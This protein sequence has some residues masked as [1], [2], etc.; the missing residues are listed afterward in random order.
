MTFQINVHV[1]DKEATLFFESEE[2]KDTYVRQESSFCANARADYMG[3]TTRQEAEV[4]RRKLQETRLKFAKLSG[5]APKSSG[6]LMFI[7]EFGRPES[8]DQI[9]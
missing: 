4:L 6:S 8:P 1:G 9:A 3:A 7:R 5:F 2:D